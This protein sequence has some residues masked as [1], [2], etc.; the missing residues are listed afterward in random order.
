[1]SNQSSKSD[2]VVLKLAKALMLT[3]TDSNSGLEAVDPCPRLLSSADWSALQGLVQ[4]IATRE[5]QGNKAS[6]SQQITHSVLIRHFYV[7]EQLPVQIAKV[8]ATVTRMTETQ[9]SAR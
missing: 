3:P 6:I 7:K 8:N 1:M 4:N 9:H 2:T 5:Q